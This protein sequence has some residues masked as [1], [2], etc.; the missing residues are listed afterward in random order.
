MEA[1]L[2]SARE[3]VDAELAAIAAGVT[4]DHPAGVALRYALDTGGK[5]L[6]PVLCLAAADAVRATRDVGPGLLAGAP[7][8]PWVRAAAAVELVHTYSLV[9]DDL[10]CMDNDDLRRGRATTHVVHGAPAA[11]TAGLALIPLAAEVLLDAAGELGLPVAVATAAVA[12]L[13]RGAGA[14]GMVGGQVLDLEAEGRALTLPELR[15]VHA[16]KTGALFEAAVRVGGRL[17]E[18]T[19]VQLDALGAFGQALGLAFQIADDVLDETAGAA[20]LGKT[21]G[22]DREA[23]KSTFPTLLGLDGARAA[24]RA[25]AQRAVAV[26]A[27]AGMD[28]PVLKALAGFAVQRHR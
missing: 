25:E 3:A 19:P 22:K 27:G 1:R 26:L 21:P 16:L 11:M 6:R 5:R 7:A 14:A 15:Q 28:N 8:G 18:A 24:A 9:H 23:L 4:A 20:V 13:C 10:P 17:A 12:D 2:A